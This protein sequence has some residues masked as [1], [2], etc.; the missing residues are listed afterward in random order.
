MYTKY[1]V[2]MHGCIKRLWLINQMSQKAQ[3]ST[4][5]L[6]KALHVIRDDCIDLLKHILNMICS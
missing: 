2:S 6:L 4:T 5:L 3:K 1:E